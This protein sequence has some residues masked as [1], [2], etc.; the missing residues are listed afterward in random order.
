MSMNTT[1]NFLSADMAVIILPRSVLKIGV[2]N[3][4]P[5]C[6]FGKALYQKRDDEPGCED[7]EEP[8]KDR[9][10]HFLG[11]ADFARVSPGSQIFNACPRYYDD[12]DGHR[13]HKK[14]LD[15]PL[16]ADHEIRKVAG[17]F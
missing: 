17:I 13:H 7:K 10:E 11:V 4:V 6:V 3:V 5:H 16:E 9:Y 2:D 15:N 14:E 12:S 8:Q 1:K